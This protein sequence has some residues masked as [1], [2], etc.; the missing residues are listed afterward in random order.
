MTAAVA[1]PMCQIRGFGAIR[2]VSRVSVVQRQF[3]N[4]KALHRVKLEGYSLQLPRLAKRSMTGAALNKGRALSVDIRMSAVPDS[5]TS[6]SDDLVSSADS[7]ASAFLG[8][9]IVYAVDGTTYSEEGLRWFA[10]NIA[11][12]GD[13][14]HLAHVI[15]D[16]RTPS[17][18]VGSSSVATQWSPARDEQVFA[19][20]FK[21][22]AEHDANEML[23]ARYIPSLEINGIDFQTNLIQLKVHKSAG[24]IA[25]ALTS[26]ALNLGADLLVIAS[27]G[28]GVNVDYGSVARWCNE[29][30]P[31][32]TML[33][34]PAVLSQTNPPS[35]IQMSPSNA[36][37]VGASDDI[38]G[39]KRCFEYAVTDHTRPGD[40]VYVMH[41][42]N[43]V[44]L[45][46][47]DLIKLRKELVTSVL[48][49]QEESP[50]PHASTLNV[51]VH[52]ILSSASDTEDSSCE[53]ELASDA[54]PA[55]CQMCDMATQLNARTVILSHHGKNFMREM[56]YK[57]LTLHC[58][59]HCTS[60]LVVLD[61]PHATSGVAGY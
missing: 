26:A 2:R 31:V 54:S 50:C 32:P 45:N 30:S 12:K 36:I 61:E 59:K 28:A 1:S 19:K 24:G 5:L 57:P 9:R 35:A 33:L 22:R 40:G 27:H 48:R 53:E 29:N 39:L 21:T 8:R 14:V 41:A 51:A 37:L 52:L 55:G 10:R 46:E 25:E 6:G 42:I 4:V 18:A 43:D 11:K 17:T 60:P 7:T 20:E 38:V 58:I 49:W 23:Q 16:S 56:L 15:C 13:I 3:N 44:N 47:E 34:P